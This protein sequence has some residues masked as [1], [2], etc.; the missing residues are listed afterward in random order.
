MG[1]WRIPADL[2]ARARFVLSPKAEIVT[3]LSALLGPRDSTER[4][5]R[6]VHGSAFEAML[7][8]F[9]ARSAVLECSFRPRRGRQ[10][11]WLASYLGSPPHSPA[12]TAED[13]LAAVA[14]TPDLALRHDLEETMQRPLPPELASA[15]LTDE[16]VGLLRWVWTHTLE[17]D[18][19]RR[20]RI[21]RADVVARTG[22][23]ATHGWAAVLRDLGRNREWVGDGQLRINRYDLPTRVLPTDAELYFIP[24]TSHGSW[25]GWI[26]PTTYAL[27]YPVTGRLAETDATRHGGLAPLVG[28][29][30]AA[31]LR[32]LDKPAGTTH[33]ATHLNLPI[34]SVGN[35]LRILLQAGVVAR[36]RSGRHVLYW[37]TPLGDALVAADGPNL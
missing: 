14:A 3:A 36:R 27:Y 20:E 26:E 5:F 8:E 23:L 21:L 10:P 32:M 1:T 7:A 2:L 19:R 25:V 31:L 9:P 16:A 24:V 15:R 13:E 33:L 30:R 11:A 29:N 12:A 37:R 34:G 6:A 22:R 28:A 35:H 4:A 17:T 18:W